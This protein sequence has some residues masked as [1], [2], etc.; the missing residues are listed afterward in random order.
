MSKKNLVRNLMSNLEEY[1]AAVLLLIM[2]SVA[3]VNVLSRYLFKMSLAF[4]EEIEVNFFV[5]MSVLGIAIAFKKNSHLSMDFLKNIAPAKV[6]NYLGVLGLVLSL[7]VFI[8]LI[9]LSSILIYNEVTLYRTSSMALD[10]PMWI[11][12][13]GMTLCSLVVVVRILQSLR[14]WQV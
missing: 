14:R 7:A 5:W 8:V 9:Y 10:I 6:R 11:Y 12:Y 3:F 13:V 4:I 1:V 2:F